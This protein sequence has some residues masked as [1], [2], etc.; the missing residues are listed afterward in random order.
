MHSQDSFLLM[1]SIFLGYIVHLGFF[2]VPQISKKFFN[3]FTE[4]NPHIS[5]TSHV[6]QGSTVIYSNRM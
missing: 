5:G 6:V 3:V 4:K 1:F 2:E